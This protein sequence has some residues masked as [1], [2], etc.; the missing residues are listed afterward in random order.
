MSS[1]LF[2]SEGYHGKIEKFSNIYKPNCGWKFVDEV[3]CCGTES[4]SGWRLPFGFATRETLKISPRRPNAAHESKSFT[5]FSHRPSC[6]SLANHS[7]KNSHIEA[8]VI[9]FILSII[10]GRGTF[11]SNFERF[12]SERFFEWFW[13]ILS[14]FVLIVPLMFHAK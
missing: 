12:C 3:I 4:I 9:Y 6:Q 8:E 5:F 1:I 2:T 10:M 11:F 13:E 7:E 14:D